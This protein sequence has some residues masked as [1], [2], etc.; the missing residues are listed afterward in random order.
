MTELVLDAIEHH[1]H[2]EQASD[3]RNLVEV[4]YVA[5]CLAH[6]GKPVDDTLIYLDLE[7]MDLDQLA[8]RIDEVG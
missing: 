5:N 3:N 4:V 2:P 1:H 7:K 8:G 6:K